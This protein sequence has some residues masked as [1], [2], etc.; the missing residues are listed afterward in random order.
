M[1]DLNKKQKKS[2]L[3][4]LKCVTRMFYLLFF[5]YEKVLDFL[6]EDY[7]VWIE[8]MVVIY[9]VEKFIKNLILELKLNYKNICFLNLIESIFK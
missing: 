6:F 9:V 8:D 1:V 3:I 2:F 5:K 7:G 4:K